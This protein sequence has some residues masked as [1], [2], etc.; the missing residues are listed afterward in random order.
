MGW[1]I[2]LEDE[3]G[4]SLKLVS[5]E[6][7]ISDFSR[8]DLS[9]TTLL[10]FLDPYGDLVFN[11]LQMDALF[12]DLLQT[13]TYSNYQGIQAELKELHEAMISQAHLYIRFAGA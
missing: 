3:S 6:Y 10:K 13:V 1:T 11:R 8:R 2:V 7:E 9:E 4:V 5:H 12:K